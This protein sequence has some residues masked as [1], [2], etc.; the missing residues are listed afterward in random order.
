[1]TADE[2]T[3]LITDLTWDGR[4]VART[5][6]G[7][8]IM[9]PGALPGDRVIAETTQPRQ[10]EVLQGRI[11]KLREPSPHRIP[12]PCPHYTDDCSASP[13]GAMVYQAALDW[14]QHHLTETL[15]RIGKVPDPDIRPLI[16]SPNIWNYRDRIELHLL[17]LADAWRLAYQSRDKPIPITNCLLATK[18]IQS[19]VASLDR[20]LKAGALDIPSSSNLHKARLL[21]RDNGQGGAVVVLDAGTGLGSALRDLTTNWLSQSILTGWQVCVVQRMGERQ[22]HF[23]VIAAGGDQ[24]V[25]VKLENHHLS[26]LPTTFTQVNVYLAPMLIGAVLDN[27][28]VRGNLLDL[29]GG[30]GAFALAYALRG[31]SGVVVESSFGA[32]ATGER[33]AEE[34][35]LPVKFLTLDLNKPGALK[36][37]GGCDSVIVDPPRSGLHKSVLDWLNRN[38]PTRIVYVSCHPAALARDLTHLTAYR[39]LFFQTLDMFP[40]TPDVET[41]SVLERK[42]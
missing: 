26:L 20:A 36:S 27:L 15:K 13:L 24:S 31:G 30:Y 17:R 8:V 21:I 38:C 2:P 5:P 10:S 35:R 19:A 22:R 18:P 7:Q 39:P 32:I 12:H 40:N 6:D 3:Y 11:I 1:L 25:Q 33:F 28:P 41:V 4:G 34:Y 29:Y 14:K 23:K 9:I 37:I 16:P 42:Q